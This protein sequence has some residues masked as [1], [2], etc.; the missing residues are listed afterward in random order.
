MTEDRPIPA[1]TDEAAQ[2]GDPVPI[3]VP[4]AQIRRTNNRAFAVAAVL[5]ASALLGC[6]CAVWSLGRAVFT[7]LEQLDLRDGRVAEPLPV[8]SEEWA[9]VLP[10][11]SDGTITFRG[12]VIAVDVEADWRLPRAYLHVEGVAGTDGPLIVAVKIPMDCEL[13][14]A[15]G[16]VVSRPEFLRLLEDGAT[17]TVSVE[18]VAGQAWAATMQL[19]Q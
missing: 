19:A 11:T 1:A 7:E 17:V 18:D 5:V 6:G 15:S 3:A 4:H 16:N 2:V 8:S 13:L 9:S 10:A 12:T 14:D